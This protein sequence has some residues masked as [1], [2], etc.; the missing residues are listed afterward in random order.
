MCARVREDC[1]HIICGHRWLP[2]CAPLNWRPRRGALDRGEKAQMEKETDVVQG[3]MALAPAKSFNI[4]PKIHFTKVFE[5][6]CV[7]NRPANSPGMIKVQVFPPFEQRLMIR[8]GH[9]FQVN[10]NVQKPP[11]RLVFVLFGTKSN[12]PFLLKLIV[13]TIN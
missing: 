10:D 6:F 3:T 7:S 13:N 2:L 4:P 1:H 12:K 8:Q 11:Y 5:E 9:P